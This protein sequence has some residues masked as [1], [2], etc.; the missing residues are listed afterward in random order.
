MSEGAYPN[1]ITE[2]RLSHTPPLS[3]AELARAAGIH[4]AHLSRIERGFWIPRDV[5]QQK[6]ANALGVT[7]DDLFPQ[8]EEA[9]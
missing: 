3:S 8:T 2:F 4:K 5:T 7:R 6:L 1:R 9:A